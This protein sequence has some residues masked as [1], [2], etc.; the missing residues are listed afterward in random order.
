MQTQTAKLIYKMLTEN[1]GIAMMDSGGD[2]GR[3]WQR[4]A[5]KTL[6]EFQNEPSVTAKIDDATTSEEL[7]YTIS[8]FHF[9]TSTLSLDE[10][11]DVFNTD[12]SSM[13][14]W[15][16]EIH[17]VSLAGYEWLKKMDFDFGES[18]N[19]Y[20]GESSLSQ[21]LQ[22]TRITSPNGIDEYVLLQIHGGADVRG[23]YTDAKLFLIDDIDQF[24]LEDVCGTIDGIGVSNRYDGSRLTSEED[25]NQ[26]DAVPVTPTSII[27]LSLANE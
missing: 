20:N 17:G 23:G 13:S 19:T 6:Q 11:C 5:G 8:T 3:M 7:Q 1:T 18:F 14:D 22:G 25:G 24:M 21:V 16:S 10:L 9:L 12:F 2:N 4:N 26:G 27:E 15:E